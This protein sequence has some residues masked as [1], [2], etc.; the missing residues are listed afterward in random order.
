MRRQPQAADDGSNAN[1]LRRTAAQRPDGAT[2]QDI[3]GHRAT[4]GAAIGTDT[5]DG[6]GSRASRDDPG[7]SGR[8]RNTSGCD[9]RRRQ[10]KYTQP[11]YFCGGRENKNALAFNLSGLPSYG[12]FSSSR[13]PGF[14]PSRHLHSPFSVFFSPPKGE[15]EKTKWGDFT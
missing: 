8:Q 12:Y 7:A 2:R 6:P 3:D 15:R 5:I 10:R 11:V 14:Q 9:V 13:R 4:V 1:S